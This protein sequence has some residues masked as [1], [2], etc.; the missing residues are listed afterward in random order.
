[1]SL[2]PRARRTR[3]ADG[4]AGVDGAPSPTIFPFIVSDEELSEEL[5]NVLEMA[6]MAYRQA[7]QVMAVSPDCDVV[8]IPPNFD[9]A[10]RV[11]RIIAQVAQLE[12]AYRAYLT[13]HPHSTR[14]DWVS[15]EDRRYPQD[16]FLFHGSRRI[17]RLT[18]LR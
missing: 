10:R 8:F 5:K 3:S 14:S 6:E 7:G 9:G 16:R 12:Q 13:E 11:G 15:E 1:M 18:G 2:G 17:D 4:R